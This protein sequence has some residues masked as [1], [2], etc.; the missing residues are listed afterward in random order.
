MLKGGNIPKAHR[1]DEI[2]IWFQHGRRLDKQPHL[3]GGRIPVYADEWW[4]WW[5]GIQP[6]LRGTEPRSMSRKIEGDVGWGNVMKGGPNGIFVIMLALHWWRLGL[7]F[8]GH[9][10]SDWTR[11][12][13]DVLWV[14]ER[15]KVCL[16]GS[17]KRT[18][19]DGNLN[20]DEGHSPKRY[21]LF[22]AHGVDCILMT[23]IHAQVQEQ[24]DSLR[25]RYSSNNP[26]STSPFHSCPLIYSINILMC[27]QFS[28]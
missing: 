7:D 25:N 6:G 26:H 22:A 23:S 11:A 5:C 17:R 19:E 15:L 2:G 27:C 4:A 20:N 12:I 8:D 18:I 24:I 10:T 9:D 3:D 13:E 1:P 28:E 16:S 14:F 21:V